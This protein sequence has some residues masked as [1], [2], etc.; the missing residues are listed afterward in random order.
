MQYKPAGLDKASKEIRKKI[1]NIE[2]IEPQLKT[3]KI[4]RL[5]L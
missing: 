2:E 5:H 3:S 4:H 1:R